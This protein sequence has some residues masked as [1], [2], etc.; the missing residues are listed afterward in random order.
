MD[1]LFVAFAEK[2]NIYNYEMLSLELL[3]ASLKQQGLASHF[4]QVEFEYGTELS[5]E[6]LEQ[7]SQ[8]IPWERIG[9]VG[10]SPIYL[11]TEQINQLIP[12]SYTHL[13]LPTIYSV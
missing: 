12:V 8:D 11:Y 13:T 5:N 6:Y 10:I 3:M 2:D 9:L 1:T 4:I 7:C